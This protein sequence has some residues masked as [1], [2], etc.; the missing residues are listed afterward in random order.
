MTQKTMQAA[1]VH[2]FHEPLKIE[3]IPVPVPGRNQILVKTEA[4]GVC[5]TDIH[6]ADGDWPVKPNLPFVPGHEGIGKVIAVGP[7]VE[8]FKVGIVR[9]FRGCSALAASVSSALR[10]GR[11]CVQRRSMAVI[12]QRRLR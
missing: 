2:K 8:S 5:H 1:V 11:H 4:C 9:A 3:E 10:A 6:A 12:R 7:G